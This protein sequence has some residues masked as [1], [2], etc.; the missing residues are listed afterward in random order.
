MAQNISVKYFIF[1]TF[2]RKTEVKPQ[3]HRHEER[4]VSARKPNWLT[5][6]DRKVQ[7]SH[8]TIWLPR[9]AAEKVFLVRCKWV[10]VGSHGPSQAWKV[11]SSKRG[12]ISY[13]VWLRSSQPVSTLN[14]MLCRKVS[15]P[16][17]NRAQSFQLS[18][19]KL[20]PTNSVAFLS[21]GK[22]RTWNI[23]NIFGRSNN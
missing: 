14:E 13:S 1:R 7:Q 18:T 5:S 2:L 22:E 9:V 21:I 3:K 15:K 4:K 16:F 19:H 23:R 12:A 11:H 8:V 20:S 6:N 10:A 17:G